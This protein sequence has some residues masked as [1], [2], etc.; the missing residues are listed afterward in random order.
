MNLKGG[1]MAL[2]RCESHGKPRG[3]TVTYVKSVKP[4]GWPNTAAICGGKGCENPGM[5]WL[6]DAETMAYNHGQRVFSFNNAS[7]KIKAQ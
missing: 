2:V 5:I 3:R 4:I 6:T 1:I 7:M